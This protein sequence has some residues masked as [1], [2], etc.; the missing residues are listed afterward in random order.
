MPA[1]EEL[2]DRGGRKRYG[3]ANSGRLV[4]GRK[5]P[6]DLPGGHDSVQYWSEMQATGDRTDIRRRMQRGVSRYSQA[7][8]GAHRGCVLQPGGRW[9]H[10]L[11]CAGAREGNRETV[12]LCLYI[13]R[14]Q[15]VTGRKDGTPGRSIRGAVILYAPG[16][17]SPAA[18]AG[19]RGQV[20]HPIIKRC[21][22]KS[23]SLRS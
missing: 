17:L 10:R 15:A 12:C 6:P 4:A 7:N 16:G 5:C 22:E 23:T 13:W 11:R 14:R 18:C 19:A 9:D 1:E 3:W 21:G 20:R 2:D 8:G